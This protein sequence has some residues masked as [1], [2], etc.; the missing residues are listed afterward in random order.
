MKLFILIL[1]SAISLNINAQDKSHFEY[2]SKE[3]IKKP[4]PTD[5]FTSWLK[6]NNEKLGKKAPYSSKKGTKVT[7][8]FI[9]DENGR[10]QNPG[11]WRGIGQGYDEYAYNL[12]KKNP[13]PWIPG[14]SENGNVKT[15]VYYQLDYMKNNNT[16]RSKSN[17]LIKE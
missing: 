4:E 11:V 2:E 16:I 17:T 1:F 12:F 14:R 13:Y 7:L 8:V 5:E 9:V 10:I 15:E 6:E 3:L